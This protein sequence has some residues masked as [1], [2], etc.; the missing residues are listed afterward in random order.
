[1]IY[2]YGLGCLNQNIIKFYPTVKEPENHWKLQETSGSIVYD[3]CGGVTLTNSNA[4]VGQTGNI[5]NAYS[6]NGSN[7]K[8]Y[9]NLTA[10]MKASSVGTFTAWANLGTTA[11][12]TEAILSI[13][14]ATENTRLVIRRSSAAETI[15]VLCQVSGTYQWIIRNSYTLTNAG[16]LH[17][18]LTQDG[19]APKLYI[20]GT[21][22]TSFDLE[23]NKAVWINNSAF[24]MLSLGY[25]NANNSEYGF[26]EGLIEDVRYYNYKL[27][28]YEINNL[29]NNG[30]GLL[31]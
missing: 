4:T 28:D 11:N 22:I 26:L 27:D 21:D 8:C 10:N 24:T 12:N 23:T 1:M 18:A 13:S 6:F 29:Y 15:E 14:K 30:K 20:N 25:T 7:S 17:I 19:T 2:N 16:W 5:A 9:A 3:Y 31:I